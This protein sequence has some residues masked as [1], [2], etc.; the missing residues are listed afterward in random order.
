V[1]ELILS[2]LPE[3]FQNNYANQLSNVLKQKRAKKQKKNEGFTVTIRANNENI[4]NL[5]KN[6]VR[7]SSQNSSVPM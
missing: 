6:L 2:K 7:S 1:A 5:L 4:I 3:N